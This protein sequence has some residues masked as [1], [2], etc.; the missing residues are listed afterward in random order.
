VLDFT[1][2][3]NALNIEHPEVWV[4]EYVVDLNVNC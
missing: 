2:Y 1:S 4:T 3:V